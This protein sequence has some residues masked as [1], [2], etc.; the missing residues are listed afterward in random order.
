[1]PQL[2]RKICV[3]SA[4]EMSAWEGKLTIC[5]KLVTGYWCLHH[6]TNTYLLLNI[7][8]LSKSGNEVMGHLGL[9]YP[10]E[11]LSTPEPNDY[12]MLNKRPKSGNELWAHRHSHVITWVVL[13]LVVRLNCFHVY[14]HDMLFIFGDNRLSLTTY[15]QRWI[16]MLH[17]SACIVYLLYAIMS[18][19]LY[20]QYN[21]G[22][23]K[24]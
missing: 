17:T 24:W 18:E 20:G 6:W 1:M 5:W 8:L 7:I 23:V 11:F 19:C 3:L 16:I 9:Y 4:N 15:R 14:I 13:K 22:L 21:I 12:F 10:I 2:C